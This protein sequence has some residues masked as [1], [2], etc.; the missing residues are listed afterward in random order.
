[1]LLLG[2]ILPKNKPILVMTLKREVDMQPRFE[3]L[4][5][6][7]LVGK[8]TKMSFSNNRTL[9]LWRGFM[10]R[11]KEIKNNISSDL[12]SIEVYEPEYFTNFV[13]ER[14]F[15]KW[16]AIEVPDFRIVPIDM[17]AITLRKD[18][19]LF[20]CTKDLQVRHQN[21]TRIFS[22]IGCQIQ[23]SHWMTDLILP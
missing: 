11:K 21:Y 4:G 20:F 2:G 9:E 14:E 3:T 6:T 15:D 17:D 8:C 10:P 1:M 7:K 23:I 22:E 13:P 12:Y 5:K 18:F 19:M 16:A